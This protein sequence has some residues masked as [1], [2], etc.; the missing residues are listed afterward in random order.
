MYARVSRYQV[1]IDKLDADVGGAQQTEQQVSQWPGS[2]GL[3]YLVDRD[4]GQ[5][6]AITMWESEQAMRESEDRADRM[7]VDTASRA[8]A[9]L[10]GIERYEV[11]AQPVDVPVGRM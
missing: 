1:P 3:Y 5:T 2:L 11:V 9:R 8:T 6:M 7:R 10:I 4:S